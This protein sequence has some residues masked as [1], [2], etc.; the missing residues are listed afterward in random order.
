MLATQKPR[1]ASISEQHAI[2]VERS[3]RGAPPVNGISL[4]G[5]RRC[6]RSP[7]QDFPR[8]TLAPRCVE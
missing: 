2:P 7:C 5:P 6:T 1:A 4:R 3:P 8:C